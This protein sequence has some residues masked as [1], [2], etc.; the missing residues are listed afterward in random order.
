MEQLPVRITA[1]LPAAVGVHHQPRGGRLG[2]KGALQGHGDQLLGH[3]GHDVPAQHALAAR[4]LKGAQIS[5]VA[6]GE[7]QI[8]DVRDPHPVGLGRVG[9]VEQPVGRA[10]QAMRRVGR[11]R[12]KG[13]GL[14]RVQAPAAHGRAQALAAHSVAILAQGHLQSAGSVAA[15]MHA[16]DPD[17]RRFPSPLLGAPPPAAGR[18]ARRNSRWPARPAP[19][20]AAARGSG[21]TRRQ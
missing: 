21:H 9:L 16:K 4:V 17:Q 2:P 7:R 20:R 13:L 19:G 15:F 14:Q 1:V 18:P 12:D 10:A 6:V 11:A 5:P 8:R 3:G